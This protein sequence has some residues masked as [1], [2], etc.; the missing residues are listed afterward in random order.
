MSQWKELFN[1]EAGELRR[2]PDA[3]NSIIITW[4]ISFDDIRERWPALVDLFRS[5]SNSGECVESLAARAR[6]HRYTPV[7]TTT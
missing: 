3:K 5:S 1:Y 6:D 2:D 7:N 4:Q